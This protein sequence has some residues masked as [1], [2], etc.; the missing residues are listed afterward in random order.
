[1]AFNPLTAEFSPPKCLF[2]LLLNQS[3]GCHDAKWAWALLKN[4]FCTKQI[5]YKNLQYFKLAHTHKSIFLIS[6]FHYPFRISFLAS[7]LSFF[8]AVLLS[9]PFALHILSGCLKKLGVNYEQIL[10]IVIFIL[11]YQFW[12]DPPQSRCR[13]TVDLVWISAVSSL[14]PEWPAPHSG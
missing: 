2:F 1:M 3:F 4:L 13:K 5:R 8:P 12:G 11:A 14:Y 10:E 9:V 7:I 6:F